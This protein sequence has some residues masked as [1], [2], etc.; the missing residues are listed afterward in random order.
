MTCQWK[1][2]GVLGETAIF[3][4]IHDAKIAVHCGHDGI[5]VQIDLSLGDGT[6]KSLVVIRKCVD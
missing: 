3:G 1:Q 4:P 2:K 5:K 6:K